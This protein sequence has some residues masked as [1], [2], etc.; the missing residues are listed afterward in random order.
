M[1]DKNTK[2]IN[3]EFL[4]KGSTQIYPKSLVDSAVACSY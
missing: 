2:Y 3:N 4:G 1:L